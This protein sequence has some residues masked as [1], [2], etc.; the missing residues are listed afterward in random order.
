M[1]T[2]ESDLH[3]KEKAAIFKFLSGEDILYDARLYKWDVLGTIAHEIMLE[4]IGTLQRDELK[5]I[6]RI[7]LDL[8]ENP[9]QLDPNLEDVHSNIEAQ[10]IHPAY[11]LALDVLKLVRDNAHLNGLPAQ[12]LLDQ[13]LDQRTGA[14]LILLGI[15]P[16]ADCQNTNLH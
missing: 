5:Q 9:I 6:L 16:V 14:I 4:E 11:K 13:L 3:T 8:L 10:I 15:S 7:L 2:W 1:R 12:P